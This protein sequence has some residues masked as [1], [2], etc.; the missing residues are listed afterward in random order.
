MGTFS[1]KEKLNVKSAALL[2]SLCLLWGLNAVAI[3]VA[4]VGIDPIFGAGL[5]SVIAT[6]CLILWMRFKNIPLFE[7]NLLDGIIVGLL[8]GVE[9]C[10]LYPSLLYTTASSAWILLYTT[11]FFHAIGAHFLLKG[12]RLNWNK[13][14]GMLLAFA[15]IIVLVSKDIGLPSIKHLLGDFLA[16]LAAILWAT[17]TIYIKPRLCS[18]YLLML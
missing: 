10:L 13:G 5:R 4:N 14:I 2:T 17:T 15:G 8:F 3:K 12:D 16:L 6:T 9:F 1:T 11:P 18:R 7:G